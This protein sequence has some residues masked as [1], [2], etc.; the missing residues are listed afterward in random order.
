VQMSNKQY[1][2]SIYRCMSNIVIRLYDFQEDRHLRVRMD[3]PLLKAWLYDYSCYSKMVEIDYISAWELVQMKKKLEETNVDEIELGQEERFSDQDSGIPML[4]EVSRQDDLMQWLMKMTSVHRDSKDG[5]EIIILQ[6][7]KDAEKVHAICR[8]LQSV[9]RS[10]N[11]RKIAKGEVYAQYEKQFDRTS[12]K[13]FYIHV[14]TGEKQLDKPRVLSPG[15]DV[16]EPPDEWR[17]ENYL[18]YQ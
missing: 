11:A 12:Q 10:K 9:W 2:L 14:R 8:K 13:Y 3:R 6:F 4:L 1:I 7:E 17:T 18:Y 5:E 16:N 15:D